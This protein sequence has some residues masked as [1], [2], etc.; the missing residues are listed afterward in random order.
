MFKERPW[1]RVGASIH[2]GWH[3][4]IC[5]CL[6]LATA[7]CATPSTE[8]HLADA[9]PTAA[10]APTATLCASSNA[11]FSD[12]HAK[13]TSSH[14]SAARYDAATNLI[15]IPAGAD[16][17][18]SD[19]DEQIEN[20]K[21]LKQVAPGD[22]LLG[23]SVRIEHEGTLRIGG[24]SARRLRL[25]SDDDGFVWIKALGGTLEI[26]DACVSSW[27]AARN[28]VDTNYKDGRSFIL[29]RDGGRM[30]IHN[31]ELSYLG[32]AE[33][34]S[35][36][37]AWRLPETSGEIVN[38]RVGYNYYGLF[39][40][41]ASGIQIV[42]NEVHHSILYG[43]DPH[44]SS[45]NLLIEKNRSHHNGKHGIILANGCNDSVIRSNEVFANDLH[46]IVL[47]KTSNNNTVEQN[48][49]YNNHQEGIDLNES[50]GNIIR[51]NTTYQNVESGIGIGQGS[52]DNQVDENHVYQNRSDGISIYSDAVDNSLNGNV[53]YGNARYGVYLKSKS[54]TIGTNNQ[55]YENQIGIYVN[56]SP[57]PDISRNSNRIYN[58]HDD[59]IRISN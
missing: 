25:R 8:I 16:L 38:S 50:S 4:M 23:A 24:A 34:E 1:R 40:Y 26:S 9:I 5:A 22:W 14:E 35:Y 33:D 53:V 57:A 12:L 44:T 3:R 56:A 21:A 36:G 39:L 37:I 41:R 18:L 30:T 58:N 54:N 17:T 15:T 31:S 59:D 47:Y 32:Y 6:A 49:V 19:L 11:S 20:D 43:I 13:K 52:R 10:I 42:G 45:N 51:S 48:V 27:D 55:I 46:G 29:A 2:R 7:A 28:N